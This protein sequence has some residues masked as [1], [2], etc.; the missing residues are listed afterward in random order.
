M[1][2]PVFKIGQ[3]VRPVNEEGIDAII[4]GIGYQP[5]DIVYECEYFTNGDLRRVSFYDFQIKPNQEN[6]QVGFKK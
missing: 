4:M 3:R 6:G 1:K 5:N 2:R